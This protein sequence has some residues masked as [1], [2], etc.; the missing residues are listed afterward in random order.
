MKRFFALQQLLLLSSVAFATPGE[1][2][3]SLA[4]FKVELPRELRLMAGRGQLSPLRHALVTIAAPADHRGIHDALT[5][6]GFHH[7][8]IEGF[9]GAHEV[10]PAP[11]GKALDWFREV[12]ALPAAN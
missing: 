8:R 6:A 10:E 5:R 12:A 1:K 7:V 4:E 9:P 11:L 3:G 2:P